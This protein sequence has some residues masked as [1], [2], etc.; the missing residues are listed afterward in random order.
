V[1]S[2]EFTVVC[3]CY[4]LVLSIWGFGEEFLLTLTHQLFVSYLLLSHVAVDILHYSL[5]LLLM[6]LKQS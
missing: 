5:V 6:R 3:A 4:Q 2:F 1:D